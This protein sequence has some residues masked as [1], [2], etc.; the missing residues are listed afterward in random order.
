LFGHR[1]GAKG[2]LSGLGVVAIGL[3]AAPFAQAAPVTLGSPLTAPLE[4]AGHCNFVLGCEATATEMSEPG[5]ETASPIAGTVVRWRAEGTTPGSEYRINVLRAN[6]SGTYT[7]TA[8]SPPAFSAGEPTEAF[9][10]DLPIAVGEYVAISFPFDA[11]LSLLESPGLTTEVFFEPPLA[12]GAEAAPLGSDVLGDESAFDAEVEPSTPPPP[13]SSPP[14]STDGGGASGPSPVG[15]GTPSTSVEAPQC[16]VPRLG[17]KRLAAAR[18]KLIG[19]DCRLGKVRGRR[20]RSALVV[21]QSPQTGTRLAAGAK[22]GIVLRSP[23][24]SAHGG[25]R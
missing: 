12:L 5:A 16:V 9:A 22:V 8:V 2:L 21:S 20:T 15:G 10:A 17:A 25:K 18:K 19:A 13:S 11:G 7:A 1:G 6:P 23:P 24:G 4:F 14:A 3:F